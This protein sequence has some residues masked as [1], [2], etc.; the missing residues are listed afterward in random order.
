MVTTIDHEEVIAAANTQL[1]LRDSQ[2]G[3]Y[4]GGTGGG[5]GTNGAAG[6]VSVVVLAPGFGSLPFK[7]ECEGA[8]PVSWLLSETIK[9][10]HSALDITALGLAASPNDTASGTG[11]AMAAYGFDSDSSAQ[12][13]PLDLT[14][15]IAEALGVRGG[16]GGGGGGGPASTTHV[17]HAVFAHE[18]TT[19]ATAARAARRCRDVLALER[20]V[21]RGV[22]SF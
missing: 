15:D 14:K 12:I 19:H 13:T 1:T 6:M 11:L 22:R 21:R 3:P 8:H 7:L 9:F 2:L 17:V 4:T 18:S 20:E 5:G 16:V 10:F